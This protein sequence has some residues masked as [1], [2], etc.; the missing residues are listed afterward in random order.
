M[1]DKEKVANSQRDT[2]SDGRRRRSIKTKKTD[3][4]D[5]NNRAIP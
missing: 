2:L 3:D 4:E 5:D 1:S